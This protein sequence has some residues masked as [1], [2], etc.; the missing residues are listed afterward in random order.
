MDYVSAG[1]DLRSIEGILI[2]PASFKKNALRYDA[3]NGQPGCYIVLI[4][5]LSKA[6][7]R[8]FLPSKDPG[9]GLCRVRSRNLRNETKRA[10][11]WTNMG[12]KEPRRPF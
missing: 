4:R 2:F 11:L 7:R 12:T 6:I 1:I 9:H 10:C 5:T 8:L 3:A